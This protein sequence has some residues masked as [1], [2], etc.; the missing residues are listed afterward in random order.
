MLSFCFSHYNAYYS[1]NKH[2]ISTAR[3]FAAEVRID[4]NHR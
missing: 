1:N 2:L 4:V 3:K